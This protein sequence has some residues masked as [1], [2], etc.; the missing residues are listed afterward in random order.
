MSS[1]FSLFS[2]LLLSLHSN[3]SLFVFIPLLLSFFSSLLCDIHLSL[4][5]FHLSLFFLFSLLSLHSPFPIYC[6][7]K[8]NFQRRVFN[9]I[10]ISAATKRSQKNRSR[11]K[12]TF[13]LI[14]FLNRVFERHFLEACSN[15][16][17]QNGKQL[18]SVEHNRVVL[19]GVKTSRVSC[20]F[21]SCVAG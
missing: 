12:T 9:Q 8:K 19:N 10:E 15:W 11:Q 6:L 2:L 16:K 5:Y 4:S 17:P 7:K 3:N 18:L 13:C 14:A 21:L 1:L 20:F